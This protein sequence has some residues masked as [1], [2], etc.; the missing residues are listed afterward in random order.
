VQLAT[1]LRRHYERS[2][3]LAPEATRFGAVGALNY[4]IDVGLFNA[5]LLGPLTDA[6]LAAK[7]IATAV[8]V[9]NSYVLN[10]IWTFRHRVGSTVGRDYARFVV[11]SL[12]GV[13]ITLGCLSFSEYVLDAHS[14]I[15]RNIAGNVVGVGLAMVFRFWSFRRWVFLDPGRSDDVVE[16]PVAT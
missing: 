3:A 6:P 14:L 7:A 4:L 10:R 2:R 13:G 12:I 9:T 8:S 1:L 11:L 16:V 5:L 15:A